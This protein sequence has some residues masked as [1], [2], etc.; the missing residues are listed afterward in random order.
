MA[1]PLPA[2]DE[3]TPP[4]LAAVLAGGRSSRMKA[5]KATVELRGRPLI[6]YPLG[7]LAA[8]GLEAVVVAKPD[9]PLPAIEAPVWPEPP[10]P[11]HPLSGILAAIRRSGRP[12]L[13][14]GCD[15]PFLSGELLAWLAAL[16]GRLVVPTAGGRLQPLLARY[17]PSLEPA[18]ARALERGDP[19]HRALAGLDRRLVSEEEIARFGPPQRL[20]LNVNT[21]E[22]LAAAERMLRA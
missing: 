2:R 4:A 15:M 21:P 22:D 19:L 3:T 14:V 11:S 7:A 5:P 8:A 10:E 6:D 13:A 16:P 18:L 9:S 1:S 20:L 17:D 12:V